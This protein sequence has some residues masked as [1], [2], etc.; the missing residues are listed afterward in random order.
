MYPDGILVNSKEDNLVIFERD[1]NN[2][3]NEGFIEFWE[4]TNFNQRF[5][6]FRKRSSKAKALQFWSSLI[7]NGWKKANLDKA[8]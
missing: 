3:N 7:N 2:P 4:L 6:T 8:A 1:E 5:L